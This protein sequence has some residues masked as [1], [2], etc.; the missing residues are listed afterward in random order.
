MGNCQYKKNMLVIIFLGTFLSISD[1][2]QKNVNQILRSGR[3]YWIGLE[4]FTRE[5][6]FIWDSNK[7]D[8]EFSNW[9]VDQPDNYYDDEDCVNMSSNGTWNDRGCFY[10]GW[11]SH[12]VCQDFHSSIF[13]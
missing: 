10:D 8:V 11:L 2:E 12:A 7:E 3:M 1:V 13:P 5:G 6:Y 4:D 9:D